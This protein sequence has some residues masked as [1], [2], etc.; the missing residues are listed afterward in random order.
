MLI[1][2][3]ALAKEK[4]HYQKILD[5]A[6][7]IKINLVLG[8]CIILLSPDKKIHLDVVHTY[9]DL[10][11]RI[12]YRGKTLKIEEKLNRNDCKGTG[13]WT[14]RIP[15]GTELEF[16]SATGGLEIQDINLAVEG[17]TGTGAI[18]LN[19]VKGEF[20]LHTGTG[21]IELNDSDGE[22]KLH[23]G[24]GSVLVSNSRGLF[25][26][27]SGTGRVRVERCHGDFG[28]HSG[29]G[30]VIADDPYI[31]EEG[32]FSS[33]TGEVRVTK[34][35]GSFV[36]LQLSSGTNNAVLDLAGQPVTGC[37]K[38]SANERRGRIVCPLKF[39]K[40]ERFENGDGYYIVKSMMK[41]KDTPVYEIS[42]GVGT[43]ELKP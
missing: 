27:Q 36:Q 6:K 5:A 10:N 29:T 12:I 11:V 18:R 7:E 41:G 32:E 15:A 25:D 19:N 13:E 1:S 37:F 14:I 33:G 8:D 24:T 28:C 16:E 20:E 34:P 22:F 9:D 42:T 26:L 43:A 17:N 31:V 30:K 3:Q 2:N 23:S 40:T 4:E 38:M 39:D 21:R 35:Q